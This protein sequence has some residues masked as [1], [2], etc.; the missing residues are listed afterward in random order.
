MNI[1]DV[2][3]WSKK[4]TTTQL[5][6]WLAYYR[7]EPFGQAWRRAGR[8]VSLLGAMWSGRFSEN[9]EETFLPT[10]RPDRPQTEEEMLAELAK[11]PLFDHITQRGQ[12]EFHD[13]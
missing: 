10:Y 12:D 9:A 1:W 7:V 4:I 6:W 2:E 5:K 8:M 3:S 11:S 13:R